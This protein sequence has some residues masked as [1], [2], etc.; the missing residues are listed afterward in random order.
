MKNY[1]KEGQEIRNVVKELLINF[2]TSKSENYSNGMKTS[3]IFRGCGFDWG[4]YE[5]ATSTNQNYWIVA[6][7][8]EL[9]SEERIFRDFG[10]KKWMLK[11]K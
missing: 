8:R 7:L 5:N 3:E 6:A 1:M 10:T 11:L 9:E 4:N 2:I